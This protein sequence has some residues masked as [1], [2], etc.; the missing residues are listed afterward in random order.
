[1][2]VFERLLRRGR[3]TEGDDAE[4]VRIEVEVEPEETRERSRSR[5]R[6]L[7]LGLLT[8]GALVVWWH[9]RNREAEVERE[10]MDVTVE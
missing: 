1:M 7:A 10:A 6:T 9:R 2:A 3:A 4:P 5:R 8:G